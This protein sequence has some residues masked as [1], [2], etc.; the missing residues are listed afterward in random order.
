M[1][2]EYWAAKAKHNH[3]QFSK[4]PANLTG[5]AFATVRPP[6][7]K[8]V[9]GYSLDGRR[10]VSYQVGQREVFE[11]RPDQHVVYGLYGVK[12]PPAK[13]YGLAERSEERRQWSYERANCTV[14]EHEI[15]MGERSW[16]SFM[17]HSRVLG[18]YFRFPTGDDGSQVVRQYVPKDYLARLCDPEAMADLARSLSRR[19]AH[20]DH[21]RMPAGVQTRHV[22]TS[23][24]PAADLARFI[25]IKSP[26]QVEVLPRLYEVW[27][28]CVDRVERSLYIMGFTFD[29]AFLPRILEAARDEA[30]PL[31]VRMIL[32]LKEAHA[33]CTRYFW[34]AMHKLRECA[35]IEVRL[36]DPGLGTYSRGDYGHMHAKVHIF[37][38]IL[39]LMT[40]MNLTGNSR[41]N[42]FEVGN[43]FSEADAVARML[44]LRYNCYDTIATIPLLRYIC[45]GRIATINVRH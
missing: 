42:C 9:G 12:S 41:D 6:V 7:P 38:E 45:Y 2:R 22:A 15:L 40:S 19:L 17:E 32:D 10:E 8:Q 3:P 5:G 4:Y 36:F 37:D 16:Q 29:D 11:Y 44:L 25:E 24:V 30:K 26:V 1:C 43:F 33:P 28:S 18:G 20:R 31:T 13:P 27:Q 21:L 34:R 39:V 23:V 14:R 35:N